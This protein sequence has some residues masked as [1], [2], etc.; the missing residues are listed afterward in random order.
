[1]PAHWAARRANAFFIPSF[2]HRRRFLQQ[3]QLGGNVAHCRLGHSQSLWEELLGRTMEAATAK[4]LEDAFMEYKV[5]KALPSWLPFFPHG[6]FWIPPHEDTLKSLRLLAQRLK[7]YRG[8]SAKGKS[9]R[10]PL[11]HITMWSLIIHMDQLLAQMEHPNSNF[12]PI[13]DKA[14]LKTM[15]FAMEDKAN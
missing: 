8:C 4:K 7:L 11:S 5:E 13:S 2:V 3:L 10:G 14:K 15:P 6:S 12:T 9:I 1:M